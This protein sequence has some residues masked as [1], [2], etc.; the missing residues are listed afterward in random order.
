METVIA[1]A[2]KVRT[3]LAVQKSLFIDDWLGTGWMDTLCNGVCHAE[4]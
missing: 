1:F 4:V 2:N 3:D